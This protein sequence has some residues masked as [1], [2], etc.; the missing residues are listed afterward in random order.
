L[1]FCRA[2]DRWQE[3]TAGAAICGAS[4]TANE[5]RYA[6]TDR[7]DIHPKAS[8]CCEAGK[9]KGGEKMTFI[10]NILYLVAPDS[11]E[12]AVQSAIFRK[13]NQNPDIISNA[14]P[15]YDAVPQPDTVENTDFPYIVIGDDSHASIDTDTENMNMVSIT[16][17]TWSRYR[18]RAE[19][20]KIQGYIYSSLQRANLDNVGF[21][22]V[23]I[24]QTASE[25]FLDSDGL[26][27]H[28]VQTF[29]LIIEE[30]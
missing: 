17:D 7:R 2:W 4:I 29:T 13:L 18:G 1:A 27:R 6:K 22:F 23:N 24:M 12:T 30:I 25:S 16:I 10:S 5:S 14:I 11:F 26:T 9:E 8:R 28:G 3:P 15:I 20:K 21:K 19:I